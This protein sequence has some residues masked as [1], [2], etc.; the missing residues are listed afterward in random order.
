M[1]FGYPMVSS[2]L[3]KGMGVRPGRWPHWEGVSDRSE[4]SGV[5]F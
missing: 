2:E 4:K 5:Y 1:E 3:F